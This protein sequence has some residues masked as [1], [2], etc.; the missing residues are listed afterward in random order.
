MSSGVATWVRD[1]ISTAQGGKKKK[2]KHHRE[3]F[4]MQCLPDN[5]SL[6]M[7]QGASFFSLLLEEGIRGSL[8]AINYSII[9]QK[10]SCA[11]AAW[12]SLSLAR[13]GVRLLSAP[14]RPLG[15]RRCFGGPWGFQYRPSTPIPCQE[16]GMGREAWLQT[17]GAGPSLPLS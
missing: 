10:G 11:G 6:K 15:I 5:G 17:C 7:W 16:V 14:S 9:N 12:A 13:S 3:K 8:K 2:R 4:K 1:F